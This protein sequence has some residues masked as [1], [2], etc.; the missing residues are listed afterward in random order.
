[1]TSF[2]H[3]LKSGKIENKFTKNTISNFLKIPFSFLHGHKAIRQIKPDLILSFG[4]TAGAISSFWAYFLGIPVVIHE[5]TATAGRANIVS[6]YFAKKILL[7][8]ESSKKYFNKNKC[9]VVGNPINKEIEKYKHKPPNKKVKTVLITGGSQGSIWINEAIY[10]IL[11]ILLEKYIVFHQAGEGKERAYKHPK[12]FGFGQVSPENMIEA[13]SDADIVIAR[14]GA[15]TVSEL[16][17]LKKPAILIPIPWT[18][19]D[20]QNENAR[21]MEKLGLATILPQTELTP[22]K[23][24]SEIEILVRDYPRVIK[25][26]ENIVSPDFRASSK[27][28]DLLQSFL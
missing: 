17:A 12:Y 11:P 10:P 16:I 21:Y 6:S 13:M 19:N 1:M 25:N 28:V 26:S 18:Y 24:L 14:A 3:N 27:V 22:Q 8:R 20:E 23:L 2:F 9:E 7:A 15:N 4:S 5:Q